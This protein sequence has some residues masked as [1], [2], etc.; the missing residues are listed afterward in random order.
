MILAITLTSL[1]GYFILR[2][3][4]RLLRLLR[5]T[6]INVLSR[7]VGLLLAAIAVQFVVDGIKAV[8]LEITSGR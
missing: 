3:S 7:L 2:E 1:A 4:G 5:Q 6:G 8:I